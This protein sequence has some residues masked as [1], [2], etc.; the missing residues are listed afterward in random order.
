MA[1]TH[2]YPF[3]PAY[4][5]DLQALKA[6]A[7]EAPFP[8]FQAFWEETYRLAREIPLDFQC[9]P[10]ETTA[11]GYQVYDVSYNSWEGRR[12][13]GWLVVPTE[14]TPRA[15]IVTGHGYGHVTSIAGFEK[16]PFPAI[17]LYFCARGF[18]RSAAG[19]LPDTAAFHVI[20]HVEDREKYIIRGCVADVWASVSALLAF[21]PEFADRLYY[22]GSSFGG[23]LGALAV[24]WDARI[25]RAFL[26]V[27]TFGNHPFRVS[28][29]CRGS[30][31][32]VRQKYLRK[33]EI[34][35]VLKYYDA[36]IGASWL[37]IPALVRCAEFDPAVPPPGQFAVYNAIPG[38]KELF[39]A[40]AGH[41]T[42]PGMEA[43]EAALEERIKEWF[44]RD[45][46]PAR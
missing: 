4:G 31:E 25:K 42:Y 36:A 40:P 5:H 14:K 6:V 15:A 22:Q 13:G 37:T 27:P 39:V 30:G 12:I 21:A 34:L 3:D 32:A 44:T 29:P 2:D 43:V 33:P 45:I 10:S 17:R 23:G 7:P 41:F 1:F 20:H 38:P 11:P 18:G 46:P 8:G 24:P 35:E 19:D 16:K 26:G 9:K 28:V